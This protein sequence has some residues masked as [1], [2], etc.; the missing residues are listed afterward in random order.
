MHKAHVYTKHTIE[1]IVGILLGE[2][3]EFSNLKK[4]RRLRATT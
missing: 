3:A 4:N 2:R 1:D